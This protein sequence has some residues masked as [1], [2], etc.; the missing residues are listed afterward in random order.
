MIFQ[1]TRQYIRV[2]T[3][4]RRM[5]KKLCKKCQANV[6]NLFR[7]GKATIDFAE[8]NESVYCK[9]CKPHFLKL[10]SIFAKDIKLND[11]KK[12]VKEGKE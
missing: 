9:K 11:L 3:E 5:N 2:I 1:K 10:K 8:E 7:E 4:T 6:V 12:V